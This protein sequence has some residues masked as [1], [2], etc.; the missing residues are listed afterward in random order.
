M[1]LNVHNYSQLGVLPNPDETGWRNI[2]SFASVCG[3]SQLIL[4]ALK[5]LDAHLAPV[6]KLLLGDKLSIPELS[7][8]GL[9]EICI[10]ISPPTLEEGDELGI[11]N[12]VS[13]SNLR[14]KTQCY[15]PNKV[16][17]LTDDLLQR[18]L[19]Q[20]RPASA[21]PTSANATGS[22]DAG[23][24]AAETTS[25]A[26]NGTSGS[27]GDGDAAGGTAGGTSRNNKRGGQKATNGAGAG[28]TN[29]AGR[30]AG[31]ASS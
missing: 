20:R 6:E 23:A 26:A 8:K 14:E 27:G 12:I 22:A 25:S 2:L 1:C 9:R 4:T 21:P 24:R 17:T 30:G 3:F 18:A 5:G 13:I 16:A 11:D 10:R 19:A 15:Q 31:Q 28:T 7:K 29:G